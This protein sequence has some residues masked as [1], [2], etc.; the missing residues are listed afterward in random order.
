MAIKEALLALLQRSPAS[1]YQLKKE[2]DATTSETWPLNIGQVSTTLQR[3]QR[4]GL[5]EQC[6]DSE[7]VAAETTVMTATADSQGTGHATSPNHSATVTR[8]KSQTTAV[9]Q[10]TDIGRDAV[11][12]WW[13]TPV[14]L[15]QRGR[16]ELVM[17]LAFAVTTPGVDVTALIQRQ[18]VALQR[19]LHDV[20]RAR[21]A[22]PP[23]DIAGLLVL[24]HHIFA[25]EAE[26]RWLDTIDD[27]R[28]RA[29]I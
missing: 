10:L 11:S 5:I 22:L 1:A 7:T 29:R 21:R 6:P 25:T 13:S 26:L 23:S 9:W 20:T 24:D 12:Q 3:L 27:R 8:T 16:D 15:E 14:T 2:F 28:L 4:D 17:K 19:L 18:R